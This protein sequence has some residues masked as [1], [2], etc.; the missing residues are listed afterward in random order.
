MA[1][2]E[3]C[4]RTVNK[5]LDTGKADDT[6]AF[7]DAETIATDTLNKLNIRENPK[8]KILLVTSGIH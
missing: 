5:L 8:T 4:T 7:D 6:S 2:T 1:V 3:G